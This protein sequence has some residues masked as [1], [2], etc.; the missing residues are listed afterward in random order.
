[1]EYSHIIVM[2][3]SSTNMHSVYDYKYSEKLLGMKRTI[4]K[5]QK[6]AVATVSSSTT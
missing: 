2:I 1:M 6:D 4:K 3:A 5:K